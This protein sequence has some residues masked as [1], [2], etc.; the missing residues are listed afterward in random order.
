MIVVCTNSGAKRIADASRRG[1][2][3]RLR[4]CSSSAP[5]GAVGRGRIAPGRS[6]ACPGLLSGPPP[7]GFAK[8]PALGWY[9]TC[10]AIPRMG[11][12]FLIRSVI[13]SFRGDSTGSNPSDSK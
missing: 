4:V 11:K 9:L 6:C 2:R 7:G 1:A 3:K 13:S 10:V 5:A 12:A 8:P